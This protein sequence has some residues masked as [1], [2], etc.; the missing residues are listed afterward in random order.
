MANLMPSVMGALAEFERD[1]IRERSREG[2]E[3]AKQ[4]GG[5]PGPQVGTRARSGGGT[6]AGGAERPTQ[7]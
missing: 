1:L 5:L 6:A 3:Q 2:I 4:R 7:A